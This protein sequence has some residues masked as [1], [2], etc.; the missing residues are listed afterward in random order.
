MRVVA[1]VAEG[2]GFGVTGKELGAGVCA[3]A[4][5]AAV[6]DGIDVFVGV[7]LPTALG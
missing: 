1:V 3:A 6:G 4:A 7:M 5:A 2:E